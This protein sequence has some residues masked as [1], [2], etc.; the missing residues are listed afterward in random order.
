MDTEAP[1]LPSPPSQ[2]PIKRAWTWLRAKWYR[3]WAFDLLVIV[4]IFWGVGRFQS[5]NL[6]GDD[7]LAPAFSLRGLDGKDHKLEDYRGKVVVLQFFAPWCTV[8]RVESDNWARI[9]GIHDDDVQ[10]LAIALSYESVQSV[11]EFMGD[12]LGAYPVLLGNDKIRSAYKIESFPTH[13]I[14]DEEGR[15]TSQSAG[16]TTTLGYLMRLL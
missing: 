10:V 16:Y 2:S 6:L 13:Y 7:E 14:L 8:C 3:R 5:R 11:V 12:D 4:V 15:I 9:Q 1:T